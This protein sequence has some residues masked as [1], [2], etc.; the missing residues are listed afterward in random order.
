VFRQAR[1]GLDQKAPN[2]RVA[3]G[4]GGTFDDTVFEAIDIDL[5][6]IGHLKHPAIDQSVQAI[7]KT[8]LS[9]RRF[10]GPKSKI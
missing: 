10:N 9:E 4:V 3:K 6:V 2:F 8:A 1:V 5:D 7:Q